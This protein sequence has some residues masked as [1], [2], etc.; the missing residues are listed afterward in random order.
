MEQKTKTF[1]EIYESQGHYEQALDIY[2]DLLK[3]NPLDFELI[4]KI[5]NTQNL[6]LS[7]RNKKKE[8]AAVKINL[9]NNLLAKIER[10]RVEAV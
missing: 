9:F 5:R 6:I 7:E 4:D 10:Y 1:A 3:A 2:I 8:S